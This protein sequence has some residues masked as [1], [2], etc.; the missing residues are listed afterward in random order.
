MNHTLKDL[1]D[2]LIHIRDKWITL[3]KTNEIQFKN[4]GKLYSQEVW[5][6]GLV[7]IMGL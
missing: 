3:S 5:C 1:K 2:K 6:S 7:V 4:N